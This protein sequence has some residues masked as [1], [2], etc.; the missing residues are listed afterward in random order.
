MLLICSSVNIN[1]YQIKVTINVFVAEYPIEISLDEEG[2]LYQLVKLV[3]LT[4]NYITH[5]Y[6]IDWCV[7][8]RA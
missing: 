2:K 6:P 1:P 3:I 5:K 4:K 7:K 8:L